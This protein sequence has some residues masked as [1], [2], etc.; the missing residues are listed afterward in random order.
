M[1]PGTEQPRV[2]LALRLPFVRGVLWRL[3]QRAS[4][5]RLK[6]QFLRF[7]AMADHGPRRFDLRWEDRLLCADDDTATTHFQRDYIYHC[8]WAA[9]VLEGTRPAQHVDI[10][11]SLAF[12]TVLSA[13]IPVSFFDYRPAPISLAGFRPGRADLNALPFEDRS[14]PSVSCLHVI[15]HV[16][17][18]RYG[19]PLNPDG[20]LKAMAELGRV[21][22]PGGNLLVAVPVG[23]PKL[24]FNAHRIYASESV[25]AAFQPLQLREFSLIPDD[26]DGSPPVRDA[27]DAL[28]ARQRYACGCFWFQRLR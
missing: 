19:D 16:G 1:S 18:G 27:G 7:A 17:L 3:G 24:A 2:S 12:S 26:D 21:L 11:S 23:R 5:R 10:G 4:T 28:V 8:A 20:D 6:R 22:A 25:R 14:L 15:E 13:F 9:R